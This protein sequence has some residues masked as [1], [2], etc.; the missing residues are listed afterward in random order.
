MPIN[1]LTEMWRRSSV[2][3]LF[4]AATFVVPEY[5]LAYIGPGAGITAIGTVLAL[6]GAVLLALIGFVW[7]PIKRLMLRN[8]QKS[9]N[10]G[11]KTGSDENK[12]DAKEEKNGDNLE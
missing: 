11:Q 1:W 2:V 5:A 6:L 7:Y 9:G 4:A 12:N 3:L 10:Q 8:K